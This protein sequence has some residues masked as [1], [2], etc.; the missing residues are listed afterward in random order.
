MPKKSAHPA[1]RRVISWGRFVFTTVIAVGL[2]LAYALVWHDPADRGA[3]EPMSVAKAP[4]ASPRAGEAPAPPADRLTPEDKPVAPFAARA[5]ADTDTVVA[6]PTLA[7]APPAADEAAAEPDTPSAAEKFSI[8]GRVL[9][10]AGDALGGMTITASATRLFVDN[11]SGTPRTQPRYRTGSEFDGRYEFTGL[12]NG[13]Y[14]VRAA[15]DDRYAPAQLAVR[16]GVQSADLV[17][18]KT[19]VLFVQGTTRSSDGDVLEGV[20]V[21]PLVAGAAGTTSDRD[22]R[23]ELTIAAAVDAADIALRARRDGYREQVVSLNPP[24]DGSQV[25]ALDFVLEPLGELAAVAG[26]VRGPAGEPLAGQHVSLYSPGLRR[27]HGAVTD[28]AGGFLIAGVAVAP[29][30]RL[31][32]AATA[33]YKDHQQDGLAVTSDGLQ[34]DIV[35]EAGA[36][37]VVR[38]QMRDARGQAVPE[39]NLTLRSADTSLFAVAVSGG[40]DGRFQ[41]TNVPAGD[42]LFVTRTSPR[43]TVSGIELAAGETLIV[44]VVLDWGTHMIQGWVLDDQGNPV[45]VPEVVLSWEHRQGAVRSTSRRVAATDAAGYFRFTQLGPGLHTVSVNASGFWRASVAQ[46]AGE[47]GPEVFLRLK[48]VAD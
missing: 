45:P 18:T 38:G 39:F 27:S 28:T 10:R 29:D 17:L 43:F 48:K 44:P 40:G 25:V 13:E 23:Y 20:Y 32:V 14:L 41:V 33:G 11:G 3:L 15:G 42:L 37:G 36:S 19:S 12:A 21:L 26:T 34:L 31:R 30:Y 1:R 5:P 47:G 35:L 9:N 46:E 22:G 16:A 6:S 7:P 8:A 24:G 4:S 2:A